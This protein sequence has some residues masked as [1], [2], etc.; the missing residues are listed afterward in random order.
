MSEDNSN[1]TFERQNIM[2]VLWLKKPSV[3]DVKRKLLLFTKDVVI[4]IYRYVC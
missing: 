4:G 1:W 2:C 3:G